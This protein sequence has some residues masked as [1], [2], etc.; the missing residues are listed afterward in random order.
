MEAEMGSKGMVV[1][2]DAFYP[3]WRASLDGRPVEIHEVYGGLRGVVTPAGRHVIEMRYRPG[4][5]FVGGALTALG[6]LGACGVAVAGRRRRL[7]P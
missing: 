7:K 5:V 4:S 2:S 6:V 1:L 3:G